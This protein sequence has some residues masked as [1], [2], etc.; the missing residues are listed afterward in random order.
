MPTVKHLPA[1]LLIISYSRAF[2]IWIRFMTVSLRVT[3]AA[4]CVDEFEASFSS[5]LFISNHCKTETKQSAMWTREHHNSDIE[6]REVKVNLVTEY[7]S[8][9]RHT[10]LRLSTRKQTDWFEIQGL[11]TTSVNVRKRNVESEWVCAGLLEM[12]FV[13]PYKLKHRHFRFPANSCS[14]FCIRHIFTEMFH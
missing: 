4:D 12:S 10:L 5:W 3:R 9:K 8:G 6:S 13:S 7:S 2:Q 1:I 11:I 14:C